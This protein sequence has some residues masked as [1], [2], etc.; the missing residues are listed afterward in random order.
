MF[1]QLGKTS[2]QETVKRILKRAGLRWKRMRNSLKH[3]RDEVLFHFFHKE[4]EILSQMAQKEEIDLYYFDETGLNLNP[5]VPY[6][7]QHKKETKPLPAQR[8]ESLTVLG[9]LSIEKQDFQ[10]LI[11]KGAANA[12]STVAMFDHFVEQIQRKTIVVL[13]NATIHT[14]TEVKQHLPRWK[15]QGLFLQFI[16]AY[17]P[18]LNKIEILWK[19]LKHFWLSTKHYTS[20]QMLEKAVENI[21]ANYGKQYCISFA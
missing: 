21:L 17:S 3:N 9:L 20:I 14:A 6:A 2:S 19:H 7:W 4:L 8:G 16:P 10:G 11:M 1:K 12:A 13:D 5:H 18:E 15:K